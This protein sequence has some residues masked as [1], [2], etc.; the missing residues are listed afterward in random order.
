[1][2]KRPYALVVVDMQP[3]MRLLA[4][5]KR[6]K[7]SLINK[8]C[9]LIQKAINDNSH[10]VLL[11][12][13]EYG[14]TYPELTRLLLRYDKWTVV[15]KEQWSGAYEIASRMRAY[16]IPSDIIKICG[17]YRDACVRE[18]ARELK[19][20]FQNSKVEIIE[21]AS[22]S[23]M[24]LKDPPKNMPQIAKTIDKACHK[25][26]TSF[27]HLISG[28]KE[29]DFSY[30]GLQTLSAIAKYEPS[31]FSHLTRLAKKEI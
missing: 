2:K 17:I 28:L 19:I 4:Q 3:G 22:I 12:W 11:E 14:S 18:T 21:R 10:I 7:R 16:N 31:A 23:R 27:T 15:Y 20:V 5:D 29:L 8:I 9:T 1:M 26:N 30:T 25:N 13:I 6:K 24:D